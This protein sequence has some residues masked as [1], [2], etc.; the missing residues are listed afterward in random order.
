MLD[1]KVADEL[2]VIYHEWYDKALQVAEEMLEAIK[3]VLPTATMVLIEPFEIFH[4]LDDVPVITK[5]DAGISR[6][7][8]TLLNKVWTR[9]EDD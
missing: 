9:R 5:V 1:K 6:G 2:R 8:D 4:K 3:K 7:D